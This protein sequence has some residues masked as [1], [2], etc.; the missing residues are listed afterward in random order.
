MDG[1]NILEN[2]AGC[3]DKD[4]NGAM[5]NLGGYCNKEVDRLAGLIQVEFDQAKRDRL[6]AKAFAIIHR[7]V[8]LIPLHQQVVAWGVLENVSIHQRADNQI[9]FDLARKG[10]GRMAAR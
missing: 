10:K 7:E 9:R 8:G 3:R 6:L 1:L 5:F 4:G 2:I